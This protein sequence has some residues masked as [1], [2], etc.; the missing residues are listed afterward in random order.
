MI[1]REVETAA[2]LEPYETTTGTT[3]GRSDGRRNGYQ[4]SFDALRTDN[5]GCRP[6]S[7]RWIDPSL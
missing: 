4:K 7:V 5:P 1:T 3:S 2:D 6:Q